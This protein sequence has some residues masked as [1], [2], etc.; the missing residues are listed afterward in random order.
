MSEAKAAFTP[1]PWEIH[2]EYEDMVSTSTSDGGIRNSLRICKPTA[3]GYC[4]SIAEVEILHMDRRVAEANARLI[5]ASTELYEALAALDLTHFFAETVRTEDWGLYEEAAIPKI[6]VAY[7][8][9][10]AALAQAR[11]GKA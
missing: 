10:V 3:D 2:E 7:E 5:A 11:G 4:Q 1:G 9:A 8:K 6:R